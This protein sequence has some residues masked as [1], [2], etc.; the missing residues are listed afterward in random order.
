MSQRPQRERKYE[1]LRTRIV[2]ARVVAMDDYSTLTD[3]QLRAL[4]HS[5]RKK[6]NIGKLRE[7]K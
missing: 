5:E 6:L 4:S 1:L 7:R 2:T 3:E